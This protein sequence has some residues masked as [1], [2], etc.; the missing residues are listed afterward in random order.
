MKIVIKSKETVLEL[1]KEDIVEV[2]ETADGVAFNLKNGLSL[3]FT[4]QFMPPSAKQLVKGTIDQCNAKDAT[5]K[6]DFENRSTPARI[7]VNSVAPPS[8]NDK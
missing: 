8:S 1:Q 4:D 6:I 3:I 5:I 2:L 7:E